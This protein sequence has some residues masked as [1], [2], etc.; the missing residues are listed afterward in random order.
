MPKTKADER[1]EEVIARLD[2][3]TERMALREHLDKKVEDHD[4]FIN[5]N[6]NPGAKSQL[7]IIQS[8]Q[9]RISGINTAIV[10]ALIIDVALGFVQKGI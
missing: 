5:G 3:I 4:E 7:A 10:I 8:S 2:R 6:G 1:H 9:K